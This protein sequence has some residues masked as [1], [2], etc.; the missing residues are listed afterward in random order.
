[1]KAFA[2][3]V[4]VA[5]AASAVVGA[6]TAA[7]ST[8]LSPGPTVIAAANNTAAPARLQITVDGDTINEQ[9]RFTVAEILV[10]VLPIILNVTFR[11]IETLGDGVD[12]TFSIRNAN[13]TIVL[14]SGF[15]GP[16]NSTSLEFTVNSMT[17]LTY[18]GTTFQPQTNDNGTIHYFC[19]PHETLGMSGDIGL[20]SAPPVVTPPP[21]R[22]TL[23]RA[24]FIGLVAFAVMLVWIAVSY[25]IV[26]SPKARAKAVQERER[27]RGP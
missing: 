11:N 6:G 24:F 25:L 9:P 12:H 3:L 16:Q 15:I 27:E 4:A 26:R 19:I 18:N 14:S 13:G 5:I 8:S 1:M 20:G 10:P 7:E 23:V 22:D 21:G 17:S 2:F